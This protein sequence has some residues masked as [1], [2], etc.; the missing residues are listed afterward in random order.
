MTAAS[1]ARSNLDHAVSW[2]RVSESR[3]AAM[4]IPHPQVRHYTAYIDEAGDEGIGKLAAGPSGGQ[5][6]WLV[7]GA[8]IVTRENDLKLPVWR[9]KILARFPKK[10]T[11]DLHFRDLKHEQKIV[12]CQEI[13][14]M[15][16]AAC[17]TLSHKVTIV[18]TKWEPVFKKKNYLYNYLIRW[19]L[20]RVTAFCQS[21]A[22]G[23]PCSL[24]VVFSRRANTDYQTMKDYLILMRDGL[25]VMRPVRSI[26]WNVLDVENIVV[27][28][29]SRWAGLQI[30]DVITS[31]FF[32][33][34]EP[35][36]YGNYEHS[37][38][39]I[40]RARLLQDH[41]SNCL[42]SGFTPVPGFGKCA[43]DDQQMEYFLHFG[44]PR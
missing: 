5:S 44:A 27:E 3:V 7:L 2:S 16:V 42:N 13:A 31:A 21:D 6:R 17:I 18:G 38:G 32:L 11:P 4:P 35:N 26:R 28:N 15:P 20:E 30:A 43:T 9:D 36:A 29:H 34:V 40:L 12:A 8:C 22:R 37:Y 14:A 23:T 39:K 25:E 33:G 1:T 10:K 19:L 24:K 41:R